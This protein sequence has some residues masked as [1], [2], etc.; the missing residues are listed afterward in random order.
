M[1][2]R[3]LQNFHLVNPYEVHGSVSPRLRGSSSWRVSRETSNISVDADCN[4]R[5]GRPAQG[6]GNKSHYSLFLQKSPGLR[7]GCACAGDQV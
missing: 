1:K 7:A 4:D 6:L 5:I 2:G 3:M